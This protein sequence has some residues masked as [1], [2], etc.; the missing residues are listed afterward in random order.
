MD[1]NGF[2]L[3]GFLQSCLFSDI[4]C[5]S[6]S[7]TPKPWISDGGDRLYSLAR[8]RWPSPWST[9][10]TRSNRP[11]LRHKNFPSSV[12]PLKLWLSKS[13]RV[14]VKVPSDWP[15]LRAAVQSRVLFPLWGCF[16]VK[17]V[18]EVRRLVFVWEW[19]RGEA[20]VWQEWNLNLNKTSVVV[21][22]LDA[23]DS[24]SVRRECWSPTWCAAAWRRWRGEAW[25]R[26]ASTG[27]REPR[28][29]LAH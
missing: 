14:F 23:F 25:T 12:S 19:S 21:F 11:A 7:W 28:V 3:N 15:K 18:T 29:T 24:P 13:L 26:W 22:F 6:V 9:V 8:W 10:P 20:E 2:V 5:L 17:L 4:S 1:I 16:L 27:F